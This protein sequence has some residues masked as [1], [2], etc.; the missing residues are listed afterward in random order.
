M[1]VV[2]WSA[3]SPSNPTI[4]VRIPLRSINFLMKLLLKSTKINKRGRG[5]PIF[6]KK[7]I[8]ESSFLW[9]FTFANSMHSGKI[10]TMSFHLLEREYKVDVSQVLSKT[11]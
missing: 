1:V 11:L 8:G 10:T 4:R 6:L 3:C 5:W 2:K 9:I 7:S